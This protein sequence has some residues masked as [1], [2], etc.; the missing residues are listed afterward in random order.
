[1]TTVNLD[2]RVD[3]ML[4]GRALLAWTGQA[5]SIKPSMNQKMVSDLVW[6]EI[7]VLIVQEPRAL[8]QL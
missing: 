8:G 7:I 5:I 1:M 2:G 6:W 4:A 3:W